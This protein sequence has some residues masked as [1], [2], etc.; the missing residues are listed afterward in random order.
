MFRDAQDRRSEAL[1]SLVKATNQVS[2]F[3]DEGQ[4]SPP[5][6]MESVQERRMRRETKSCR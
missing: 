1:G 2:Q 3:F 5:Q 6:Q 4:E